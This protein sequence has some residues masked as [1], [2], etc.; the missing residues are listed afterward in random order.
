M[1]DF[2]QAGYQHPQIHQQPQRISNHSSPAHDEFFQENRGEEREADG[3]WQDIQRQIDIEYQK[4]L[5]EVNDEAMAKLSLYQQE[6]KEM[7]EKSQFIYNQKKPRSRIA[8]NASHG[9]HNAMP[10][11]SQGLRSDSG[12]RAL[13]GSRADSRA[14]NLTNLSFLSSNRGGSKR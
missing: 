8:S 12:S 5:K 1:Y 10:K 13:D 11:L 14:S 9:S 4:K 3:E 6:H 7:I 2:E